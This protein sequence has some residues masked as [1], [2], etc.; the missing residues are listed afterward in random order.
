[1]T[2]HTAYPT[3][4]HFILHISD[5]HFVEKREPLHGIVDSD[6]NLQELFD[7]FDKSNTRPEAIVFT[8]DIA[9]T[10]APDAYD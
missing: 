5:T 8:G 2:D 9:D 3:P 1:M 10:A 4:D 6:A 7:G